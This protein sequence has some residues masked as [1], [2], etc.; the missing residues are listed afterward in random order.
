MTYRITS[1]LLTY[2]SLFFSF[3]NLVHRVSFIIN[4]FSCNITS[5]L[6]GNDGACK[7]FKERSLLKSFNIREK[8]KKKLKQKGVLTNIEC[9][10][11]Y[12]DVVFFIDV[13]SQL[14]VPA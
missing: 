11:V 5:L 6:F 12:A 9:S 8:K 1:A 4:G 14:L 3:S 13:V 7:K 10:F 2:P